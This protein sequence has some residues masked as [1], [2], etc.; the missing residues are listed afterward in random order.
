MTEYLV[1]RLYGPMASWGEIAV[2]EVRHSSS[3]PG[4]SSIL[5]II[6]AALGIRR[7]E[8]EKLKALF[9]GYD[10][11]IKNVYPGFL[12][13]DYHTIQVPDSLCKMRFAT[14]RDELL[15]EKDRLGTILSTREYRCDSLNIISIRERVQSPYSL[16]EI[17]QKLICPTFVLYLGRKSCPLSI[18]LNP[19]LISAKGF[20]DSFDKAIFP[21]IVTTQDGKDATEWYFQKIR[22]RYYWDGDAFDMQAQQVLER[23]DQ[24][25]DRERWQFAP[26][27]KNYFSDKE[28]G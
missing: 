20:K 16:E 11:G 22:A 5:G 8:K 12:L 14:R 17:Q 25:V 15:C 23:Y 18:P 1:F 28:S 3:Y 24:P 21:P 13:R 27:Q 4:R 10:I 7:T 26:R 19:Q 2:G 6:S 9:D